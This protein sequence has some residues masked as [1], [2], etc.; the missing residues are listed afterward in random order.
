MAQAHVV[1]P[2]LERILCAMCVALSLVGALRLTDAFCSW[3]PL[4]AA[5]CS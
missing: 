3:W 4:L 1:S 5:R 2:R